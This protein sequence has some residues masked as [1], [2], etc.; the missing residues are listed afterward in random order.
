[1]KKPGSTSVPQITRRAGEP[2]RRSVY[3]FALLWL[4]GVQ[5]RLTMLAVP[6]VLP[7]IRQALGLSEKA[8]GVLSAMPV[9]LLGVAAVFGSLAVARL[10][11][12]RACILSLVIVAVAGAA[13]GIGPSAPTLYATTFAMGIGVA[14]MQPTLPT[15]V[16]EWFSDRPGFATALYANGLLIGE[17]VPAALTI[18]LVLP[19]VGG[20]WGWSFAVWSVPVAATAA[21]VIFTTSHR[22]RAGQVSNNRWWPDWRGMFPWSLGLL[23]GGTGGLY[24]SINTF[25]PNYLHAIGEPALV[26]PALSALNIGQVPASALVLAFA[27]QMTGSRKVLI[28]SIVIGALGIAGLLPTNPTLTVG[29]CALIGFCCG[30]Q[31]VLSLASPPIYAAAAD[32]HRL[33]AAMFTIGYAISFA[34]PPL[35]GAIWD[36]T[37]LPA[38]AYAASALSAALALIG[39]ATLPGV[40]TA[41]AGSAHHR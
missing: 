9:L 10:G 13:R 7:L 20:D 37:G 38:S 5:L 31:L 33:S 11:A 4:I 24:F 32:V 30:I 35:G 22:E 28:A 1:M 39:A 12:R 2:G 26:G 36:A 34:I 40:R 21:L 29:A 8:I 18:P 14:L 17:A 16:S 41:R 15:L 19:S 23:L 3:R 6:P 27:R 25:I